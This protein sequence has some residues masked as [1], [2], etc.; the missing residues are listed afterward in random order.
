VQT[1]ELTPRG[2][3][4]LAESIR[5]LEGFTP[6][7]YTGGL[8]D[9]RLAFVTD[10]AFVPGGA[11][12]VAGVSVRQEDGVVL[13]EVYGDAD[14]GVVRR[15]VERILSL[16]VDGDGFAAVSERDPVVG[17][18][19][20]RYPGLRPV[21]FLSPYEA[22]AWV[23]IGNRIRMTQAARIKERMAEELGA[24][25][26]VRDATEH[27]FPGPSRLAALEG[28]AGLHEQK[29][30]YLRRLGE[31]AGSGVLDA[32]RLRQMPQAEAMTQMRGLHG[33]GPFG[34]ELILLRGAGEPDIV[35]THEP[36]L[37]HAVA[38]AYGLAEPPSAERLLTIA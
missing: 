30:A 15:Q 16:D 19:E 13:G 35:P 12:H 5:F 6:A 25:V 18:L 33:I 3:F 29:I 2:P 27:A 38:Q 20:A 14:A 32:T 24:A 28:F 17:R 7:S 21:L 22:A 23:L 9:L 8:I 31:E 4:S 10:A 37:A 36:R 34:A 26:G 1:F 11:E